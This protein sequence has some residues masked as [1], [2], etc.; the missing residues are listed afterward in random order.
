MGSVFQPSY[1]IPIPV[2]ATIK[3]GVAYWTSKGKSKSGKVVGSRV[4][5]YSEKYTI[6]YTDENN[7]VRKI[8]SKTKDKAAA[9]QILVRHEAE[10]AKIRAGILTRSD[11]SISSKSSEPIEKYLKKFRVK[12]VAS[13]GTE[14]HISGT[15]NKIETICSDL[16]ITKLPELERGRIE[17]WIADEKSGQWAEN[18]KKGYHRIGIRSP[19]TINSYLVAVKSFTAWCVENDFLTADPLKKIKK[20][21]EEVDRRKNRRSLTEDE[22]R[23]LFE[24][25]RSRKGRGK[26]WGEERELIYRTLV[27]TGLRSRELSLATPSQFDFERNRFTVRAA[28]TKNKKPDVLPVRPDL[29]KRIKNWIDER[30][31]LPNEP[32]FQFSIF[33]LRAAFDRDCKLVGIEKISPDGR[34]IDVHSLRRTFGT[35]LARAGVPLTTTQRLMRHSTPE[36]TA[37]LYIDVDPIDMQQAVDKLPEL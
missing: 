34:S 31:I 23:R 36:L 12:M 18:E 21:N 22:L 9:T 6:K 4:L 33:S 11:I 37:K 20:L 8:A 3:D 7:K 5:C 15:I 30:K 25:A 19:R 13:G 2:N 14:K 17:Q 10:V 35:M 28:A 29:A 27:G 16:K 1:S 26:N 24:A 32:I